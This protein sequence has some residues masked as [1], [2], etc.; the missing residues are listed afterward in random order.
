M[1]EI[2]DIFT[3]D[4]VQVSLTQNQNMI[5]AFASYAANEALTDRI[6]LWR[7]QRR[8]EHLNSSAFGHS[9]EALSILVVIVAN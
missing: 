4:P 1:I 3:Y 7:P 6:R 2:R 8:S 9:R 5:Q